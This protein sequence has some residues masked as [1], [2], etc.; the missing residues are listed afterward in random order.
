MT[1]DTSTPSSATP[2]EGR[3]NDD[4][5]ALLNTWLDDGRDDCLDDEQL[6]DLLGAH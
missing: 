3:E 2:V 6:I 5:L 1:A 4:D